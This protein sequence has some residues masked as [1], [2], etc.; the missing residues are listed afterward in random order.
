MKHSTFMSL[1]AAL[2]LAAC[3][4]ATAPEAVPPVSPVSSGSALAV[5]PDSETVWA[6]L[7]LD[8]AATRLLSGLADGSA[9]A[10][11]KRALRGLAANIVK[12]DSPEGARAYYE[13]SLALEQLRESSDQSALADLDAVS[14]A[15]DRAGLLVG[16]LIDPDARRNVVRH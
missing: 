14:F 16:A 7:A 15:L 12:R 2:S 3:H 4:D 13:A 9:R 1:T 11:L 5:A 10:D 6:S 8:D